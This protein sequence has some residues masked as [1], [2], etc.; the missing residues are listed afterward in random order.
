MWRVW[1]DPELQLEGPWDEIK[2][3]MANPLQKHKEITNTNL[4]F[5]KT[6]SSNK[7]HLTLK[8][9]DKLKK[10]VLMK[11]SL[12][13]LSSH[14]P[15]RW[16]SRALRAF[17]PAWHSVSLEP[18]QQQHQQWLQ[19]LQLGL[20]AA[21]ACL[22]APRQGEEVAGR[23][24]DCPGAAC[25]CTSKG[26]WISPLSLLRMVDAFSNLIWQ[27]E[28]WGTGEMMIGQNHLIIF[29]TTSPAN[30]AKNNDNKKSIQ[31]IL[32]WSLSLFALRMYGHLQL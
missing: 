14:L 25:F 8:Y 13:M 9:P 1:Q 17:H 26:N 23:P 24:L 16:H 5:G 2:S 18:Q 28:V 6:H 22:P 7:L 27:S 19:G 21:S 15:S 3:K 30:V 10:M 31:Q 32:I 11:L 20:A 4:T 12:N 29:I